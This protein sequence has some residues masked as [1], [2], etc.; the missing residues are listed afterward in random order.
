MLAGLIGLMFFEKYKPRVQ[1]VTL[2]ENS[3]DFAVYD[4]KTINIVSVPR[5]KLIDSE[6]AQTY[7]TRGTKV[8]DIKECERPH[9][10]NAPGNGY[11]IHLDS[12]I[13]YTTN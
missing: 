5:D 12:G 7:A 13:V 3:I 10:I 9:F 6:I 4:S 2:D 1:I 8:I 11:D